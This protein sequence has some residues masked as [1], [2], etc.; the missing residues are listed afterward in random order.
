MEPPC[1]YLY[2]QLRLEHDLQLRKPGYLSIRER[3]TIP[4]DMLEHYNRKH[5]E[6]RYRLTAKSFAT[7]TKTFTMKIPRRIRSRRD[8]DS[9]TQS[10][11]N[12]PQEPSAGKK[13][14]VMTHSEPD[15]GSE[16]PSLAIIKPLAIP[17]S[18]SERD[19]RTTLNPHILAKPPSSCAESIE[20]NDTT[21]MSPLLI[22]G[23]CKAMVSAGITDAVLT[24]AKKSREFLN[25]F[26]TRFYKLE[27]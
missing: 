9:S 23:G 10:L 22:S 8:G 11:C 7:V 19:S 1:P 5:P 16:R 18:E 14:A 17:Q 25:A 21:R 6:L 24:A 27:A 13:K 2:P 20:E 4:L 3:Y 12:V 26:R 15:P